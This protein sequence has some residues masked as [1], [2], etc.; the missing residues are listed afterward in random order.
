MTHSQESHDRAHF[1]SIY[2]SNMDPWNYHTS[3]YEGAKRDATIVALEGRRFVSAIEVGCSIGALTQRLADCC[4]R[5]LAVD[6]IE[7]A[8]TAARAA[9]AGK[10]DV[11]FL[12]ARIPDT[13]PS[14]EFDLIV[15]SEVL[16]FLSTEDNLVLARH[17]RASLV[18][19]GQILLVNWL[20]KSPDDPCSGDAAAKRFISATA[21]FMHV[22]L[23]LRTDAFRLDK[24]ERRT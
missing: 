5:L 16:Y 18:P 23:R 7:N 9:C 10:P 14:G 15:L 19:N 11:T 4:D 20:G 6:F 1:Q 12:N 3:E 2:D 13:W 8:L 24:L 21:S 22:T 17:C